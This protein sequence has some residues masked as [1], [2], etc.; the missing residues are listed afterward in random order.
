MRLDGDRL[1]PAVH[2]AVLLGVEAAVADVVRRRRNRTG[3]TRRIILAGH[4]VRVARS[5]GAGAHRHHRGHGGGIGGGLC[6][7]A[8]PVGPSDVH[9]EAEKAER[10]HERH[11]QQ[12][13]C[14]AG[15]RRTV[16]GRLHRSHTLSA[17]CREYWPSSMLSAVSTVLLT[18]LGNSPVVRRECKNEGMSSSLRYRSEE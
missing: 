17:W 6:C 1:F 12:D 10:D 13:G 3:G 8:S 5:Q 2:E 11:R 15:A 7:F 9:H 18:G 14:L 4:A 16:T